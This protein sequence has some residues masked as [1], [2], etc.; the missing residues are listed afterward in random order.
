MSW[1]SLSDIYAERVIRENIEASIENIPTEPW[2]SLAEMYTEGVVR[3]SLNE[4]TVN[5]K[6][7]DTDEDHTFEL[8]DIYARK[9]LG[10][11]AFTE[12]QVEGLIIKW[13]KTG[14]W[15]DQAVT[16]I[17]EQIN[18]ALLSTFESRLNDPKLIRDIANDIE[19]IIEF[20]KTEKAFYKFITTI[21]SDNIFNLF[22]IPDLEALNDKKF[23]SALC[24]IDITVNKVGVG[25]GEVAITLFTEATHPQ[26]PD[27][28]DLIVEGL[29][30][31]LKGS[32]GRVGKGEREV[33]VHRDIID[34]NTNPQALEEKQNT[35]FNEI[36][37][38]KAQYPKNLI[39]DFKSIRT[40]TKIYKIV[41]YIYNSNSITDFINNSKLIVDYFT[42]TQYKEILSSLQALAPKDVQSNLD[43]FKEAVTNLIKIS[44]EIYGL[45]IGKDTKQ[46]R[47]FFNSNIFDNNKNNVKSIII[48]YFNKNIPAE[49]IVGAITT[50]SYQQQEGFEYIIFANTSPNAISNGSLPCRIIGP[51]T[52]YES[53]L[54]LILENINNVVFSPNADR[55]SGFQV[56][57]R[58][59]PVQ[60]SA[61]Q[62]AS[63]LASG[64]TT[65]Q[66]PQAEGERLNIPT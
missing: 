17:V 61:E 59:I 34:K 14:N 16:R 66:D 5:I 23:I 20:K 42:P 55:G 49:S 56:E 27:K 28:G 35:L 54:K 2:R 43:G 52:D 65:A 64:N 4:A 18:S 29:K 30:V 44:Y 9:I 6:F 36:I 40:E 48:D 39:L 21:G 7:H 38:I 11:T 57:F 51:F 24:Q 58:G 26:A 46:F 3:K 19:K 63:S 50:A 32:G 33:I 25:P 37:K 13:V 8:K 47:T 60:Q 22:V 12:Q 45:K 53:N 31:E 41:N 15:T 1:K 62:A 10:F